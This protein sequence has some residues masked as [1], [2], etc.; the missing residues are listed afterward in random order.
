[1]TNVKKGKLTKAEMIEAI[2]KKGRE[3]KGD[4]LSLTD[5]LL[6]VK[7]KLKLKTFG[8][9]LIMI[10]AAWNW[11]KDDLRLQPKYCIQLVYYFYFC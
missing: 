4:S 3:S 1:M 9:Q 10:T 6:H 11:K 2:L 7:K 5:V 8:Q